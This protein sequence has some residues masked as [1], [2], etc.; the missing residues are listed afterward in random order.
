MNIKHTDD[1]LMDQRQYEKRIVIFRHK[2]AHITSI[3]KKSN[4]AV[5]IRESM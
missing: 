1:K 5:L 4:K 3:V 2:N